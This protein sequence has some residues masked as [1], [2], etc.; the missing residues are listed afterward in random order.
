MQFRSKELPEDTYIEVILIP[1]N[2]VSQV[3]ERHVEEVVRRVLKSIVR[4]EETPRCMLQCTLQVTDAEVDE[5]LPGGVKG[6]G[7]GGSYLEMLAGAVNCAVAGCLDGGVQMRSVAGAVVVAVM[8]DGRVRV[9]PTLKE[10]KLARSLHVFAFNTDGDCLLMESEGS[11]EVEEW[12]R[13]GE[14]A[15]RVVTGSGTDADVDV[16][17]NEDTQSLL[18]VMRRAVEARVEKDGSWKD[19]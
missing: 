15:R 19:D 2:A 9:W 17:M 16:D 5:S 10:R 14:A 11:F 4:G 8:K 13:A 18:D 7:Q 3:K 1:H 12:E 6:P